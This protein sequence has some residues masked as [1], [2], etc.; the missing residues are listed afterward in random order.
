MNQ[1]DLYEFFSRNG[2][3]KM[4][5]KIF[6]ISINIVTS[7]KKAMPVSPAC[8]INKIIYTYY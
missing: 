5:N 2:K 6:E 7:G 1:E 3:F 8:Y 4:L